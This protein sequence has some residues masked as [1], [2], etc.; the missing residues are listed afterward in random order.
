MTGFWIRKTS[1]RVLFHCFV[2]SWIAASSWI[3]E[4]NERGGWREASKLA[5]QAPPRY[6]TGMFR[7]NILWGILRLECKIEART[8]RVWIWWETF[9]IYKVDYEFVE[10]PSTRNARSSFDGLTYSE[11]VKNWSSRKMDALAKDKLTR[12]PLYDSLRNVDILFCLFKVVF[13]FL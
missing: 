1:D 10:K 11:N 9:L 13:F 6:W 2:A 4:E 8:I 5:R 12:E 7:L 3:R